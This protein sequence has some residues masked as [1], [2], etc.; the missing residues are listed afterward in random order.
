MMRSCGITDQWFSDSPRWEL[1]GR[2]R[3]L[4]LLLLP[5]PGKN[6][7]TPQTAL[8]QQD[9]LEGILRVKGGCDWLAPG[10]V[11]LSLL[12]FEGV[13]EGKEGRAGSIAPKP[14][15]GM[16]VSCSVVSD[17]LGPLGL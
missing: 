11:S 3:L 5:M 2:L 10:S 6:R 13:T 14:E 12:C 4:C 9:L 1:P 8:G 16:C 7:D 15:A 17:F